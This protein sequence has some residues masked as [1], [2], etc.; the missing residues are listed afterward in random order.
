MG[1]VRIQY[2][3]LRN[4]QTQILTVGLGPGISLLHKF[5]ADFRSPRWQL[6]GRSMYTY[7]IAGSL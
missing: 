2:G 4:F 7:S 1:L 5:S 3:W 6:N